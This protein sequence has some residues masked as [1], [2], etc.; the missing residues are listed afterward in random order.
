[1]TWN[2]AVRIAEEVI[3]IMRRRCSVTLSTFY[4][5]Y[6]FK[7]L[8]LLITTV[9]FSTI[10]ALGNIHETLKAS[11]GLG[12]TFHVMWVFVVKRVLTSSF[13]RL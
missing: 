8:D 11:K 2:Q 7:F 13:G 4:L 6:A 10:V 9:S 5:W 1:M 3:S 12:N